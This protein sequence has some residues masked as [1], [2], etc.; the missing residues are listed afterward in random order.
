MNRTKLFSI[1][2]FSSYPKDLLCLLNQYDD[3]L[4]SFF[5]GKSACSTHEI[6]CILEVNEFWNNSQLKHLRIEA[7][8]LLQEHSIRAYHNTRL[9]DPTSIKDD[10]LVPLTPER[11]LQSMKAILQSSPYRTEADLLMPKLRP[12][13]DDQRGHRTGL[14]AFFTPYTLARDYNKFC[15]NVG[16]E[17]AEF[18]FY[19]RPDLLNY[20]G[21]IGCPVTVEF[22]IPVSHIVSYR[23]DVV[24]AEVVRKYCCENLLDWDYRIGFDAATSYPIPADDILQ[25]IPLISDDD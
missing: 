1:E 7:F 6:H 2:D 10:G 9:I 16:G 15:I 25:I 21:R 20:L 8:E 22:A 19:D 24:I 18:A 4:K 3:V 17:V 5:D 13:M 11:Y 12:Y 14:V 23:T